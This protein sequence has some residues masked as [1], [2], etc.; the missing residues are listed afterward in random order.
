M[1]TFTAIESNK[2]NFRFLYHMF[3]CFDI[4]RLDCM[5]G[6]SLVFTSCTN[7]TQIDRWQ[8]LCQPQRDF[9]SQSQT[10]EIQPASTGSVT[11]GLLKLQ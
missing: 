7:H 2:D 9:L 3:I 6:A 10:A 8:S 4:N 5:P 1:S 11:Q